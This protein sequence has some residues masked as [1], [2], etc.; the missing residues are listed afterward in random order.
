MADITVQ[1]PK[2]ENMQRVL[3]PFDIPQ[4]LY[5]AGAIVQYAMHFCG[6]TAKVK[7][8]QGVEIDNPISAL[9]AAALKIRKQ[10]KDQQKLLVANHTAQVA[11]EQAQVAFEELFND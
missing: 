5:D 2:P 9:Q 8:L 3:V 1:I 11:R 10:V 7:N 6:W 4:G